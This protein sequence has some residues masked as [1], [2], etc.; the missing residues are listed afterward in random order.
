[1]KF[2]LQ[3]PDIFPIKI[4]YNIHYHVFPPQIPP[5]LSQTPYPPNFTFSLS[6]CQ[7][8][9]KTKNKKQ[10]TYKNTKTKN[11]SKWVKRPRRPKTAKINQTKSP[12]KITEFIL[13]WPNTLGFGVWKIYQ[14]TFHWRKPEVYEL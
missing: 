6:A 5:R 12:Q 8:K 11:Q 2:F 1:M 10:K 13:L 7:K 14:L 9:E 4:S 3:G